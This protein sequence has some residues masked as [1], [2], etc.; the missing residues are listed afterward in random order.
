ML[1][2]C[3]PDLII[4]HLISG[5]DTFPTVFSRG[6]PHE[7]PFLHTS[8]QGFAKR[9]RGTEG[10]EWRET[11]LFTSEV[12]WKLVWE[13]SSRMPAGEGGRARGFS[14]PDSRRFVRVHPRSRTRREKFFLPGWPRARGGLLQEWERMR[15]GTKGIGVFGCHGGFRGSK[16]NRDQFNPKV[17]GY[18]LILLYLNTTTSRGDYMHFN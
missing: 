1:M 2:V 9:I 18:I 3:T 5:S 13:N 16:R 14:F 15:R 4:P 8:L 11:F 7:G 10:G 12:R 6:V 17:E